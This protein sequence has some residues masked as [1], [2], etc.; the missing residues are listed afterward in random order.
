MEKP[1]GTRTG[2]LIAPTGICGDD[3]RD[4]GIELVGLHPAKLAAFQ[5][6]LG[7]AELRGDQGERRAGPQFGDHRFGEALRIGAVGRIIDRE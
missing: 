1:P 6:G 4:G 5:R 7:L 2:L 3:P